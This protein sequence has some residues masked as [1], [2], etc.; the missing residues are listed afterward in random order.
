[1]DEICQFERPSIDFV[2][3]ELPPNVENDH[4]NQS[5]GKRA[6]FLERL[7]ADHKTKKVCPNNDRPRL[8]IKFPQNIQMHNLAREKAANDEQAEVTSDLI[9]FDDTQTE[10]LDY[11]AADVMDDEHNCPEKQFNLKNFNW[12]ESNIDRFMKVETDAD[13]DSDD[14]D[15]LTVG[16]GA[17]YSSGDETVSSK[18]VD[19]DGFEKFFTCE[20]CNNIMPVRALDGHIKRKHPLYWREDKINQ[21]IEFSIEKRPSAYCH[22]CK[23]VMPAS[24][25]GDHVKRKHQRGEIVAMLKRDG[26]SDNGFNQMIKNGQIY[27]KDGIIYSKCS[28]D[29][30]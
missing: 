19:S 1:M 22:K 6:I 5:N 14:D 8:A 12:N 16:I 27:A 20:H 24:A 17:K 30:E 11:P 15:S 29:Q 26:V 7:L 21:I 9:N 3:D 13:D 10:L 18:I 4:K 2:P 23:N 25:Y 28:K